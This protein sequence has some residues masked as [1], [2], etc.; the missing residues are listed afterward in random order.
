MERARAIFDYAIDLQPEERELFLQQ[1]SSEDP[2]LLQEVQRMLDKAHADTEEIPPTPV[3]A[4]AAHPH[5]YI[6]SPGD[7]IAGRYRV[8]RKVAKGGMGEVYEVADLELHSRVALKV[9]SLKSA[10]KPNAAEMFRR[11][12]LLARQVTHPNVCRIY[13]IGHHEHADHGDLMFLTMEFLEGQTLADRVRTQGT[14]SKEEALPLIQQMVEALAAAHRL[15]IAHRDFKSANV[16][17]CEPSSISDSSGSRKAASSPSGSALKST[18]NVG[19][20][21]SGSSASG[22]RPDASAHPGGG[23]QRE[24]GLVS[25][26]S[27]E[28]LQKVTLKVTDFGLARSVD[29]METTFHGEVWGTPDYM[30]PE[31]FHG[32]QSEYRQRHLCPRCGDLRDVHRQT[33]SSQQHRF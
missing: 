31:Q 7:L 8:L 2:D 9:I 3:D 33:A 26:S 17:L 21:S 10:A 32:F 28:H 16:I 24:G 15:N 30:A 14:L 22:P 18:P 19:G 5:R 27:A 25:S 13:D 4:P 23:M 6:F 20:G 29:G 12:I 11:E 1:I